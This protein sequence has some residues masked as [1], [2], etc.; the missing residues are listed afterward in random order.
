MRLLAAAGQRGGSGRGQGTAPTGVGVAYTVGVS[1]GGA[2]KGAR[3]GHWKGLDGRAKLVG[4][5]GG[6]GPGEWDEVL[7]DGE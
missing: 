6:A 5:P 2:G 3:R 4:T 1:V 7:V